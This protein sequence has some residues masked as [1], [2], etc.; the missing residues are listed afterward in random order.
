MQASSWYWFRAINKI[1]QYYENI[2]MIKTQ[3][4][5]HHRTSAKKKDPVYDAALTPIEKESKEA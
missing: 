2:N 5:L 1:P 4:K 3:E